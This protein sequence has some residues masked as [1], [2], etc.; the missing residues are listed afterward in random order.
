MAILYVT[1]QGA[2]LH[3]SGNQVIVKKDREVLQEIPIVQLDEIVIFGNGHLTT[4]AMGY[5]LC[6]RPKSKDLGFRKF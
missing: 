6:D 5:L 1:Q 3:K 4:Q 2:M